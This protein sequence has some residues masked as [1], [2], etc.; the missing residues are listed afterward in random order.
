MRRSEFAVLVATSVAAEAVAGCSAQTPPPSEPPVLTP[1]P[2]DEAVKSIREVIARDRADSTLI[3]EAWPRLYEHGGP[4]DDAVVLFH[5]FTNCPQQFDELARRFY[6][7][8]CNVYVPRIPLHG[9][10]DRLTRALSGLTVPILQAAAEEAYHFGSGL[11]KHVTALGLSLGG[12]M[13]LW[14]AQTQPVDLAVPV[15]PFIM[16]IGFARGPGMLAMRLLSVLPDMYWWWDPRVKENSLPVYAYPGY[17]THALAQTVF[18][19]DSLF[20]QVPAKPRG[21]RVILVTNSGEPA[22]NNNV[23]VELI[24]DWTREGMRTGRFIFTDLGPPRHDIIDPTTF[25]QART[26]VYPKLEAIVLSGSAL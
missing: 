21:A 19:G 26:L 24:S 10:K 11:G 4:V 7:R 12:S 25:P 18:L 9:K 17:T 23:T 6:T 3:A 14:I 15:S 1:P 5:G 2:F 13:A 16:P 22:V 8:G 20:A